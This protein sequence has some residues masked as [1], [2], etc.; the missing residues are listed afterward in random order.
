MLPVLEIPGSWVQQKNWRGPVWGDP[1]CALSMIPSWTD[2]WTNK[3][4]TA[5]TLINYCLT[6]IC[7]WRGT[8]MKDIKDCS[9]V[10]PT[11]FWTRICT[12]K[13]RTAQMIPKT[14]VSS[15]CS[16]QESV[17]TKVGQHEGHQGSLRPFINSVLDR[18]L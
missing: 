12:N 3:I 8:G 1:R 16:G 7:L 14:V 13:I 11:P 4:R 2:L 17:Q 6:P 15:D 10:P 5:W 9:V 18:N